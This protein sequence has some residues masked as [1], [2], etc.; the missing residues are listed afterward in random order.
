MTTSDVSV[1]QRFVQLALELDWHIPGYV[2]SYFGP[3]EWKA[4]ST[5]RGPQPIDDL[6]RQAEA[7]AA[8][9][10][11]DRSLDDQRRDYLARH[12]TAMQTSLRLLH[13]EVM[14]LAEETSLLYDVT[15]QWVDEREFEEAHRQ[16]DE[17]LQPGASLFDRLNQR[18]QSS[19]MSYAQAEPLLPVITVHLRE[20]TRARFPLP[21]DESFELFAVDNQPWR[22]YNWYLGRGRSRIDINTDL[23]LQIT[24][25]TATLAHE[26]YPGHHTELSIKD[27]RLFRAQGRLE[28]CL[29]FMNMPWCLVA[30]GIA[31]R[32]LD[33]L[34]S[35][36][37]Q[38]RWHAE[39]IFPRAGM[40]HLNAEREYQIEQAMRWLDGVWDNAAFLLHDQHRSK[41]EVS[42]YFQRYGLQRENEAA[43]AVE[44]IST[45]LQRSYVFNYR[46]GGVLLD[47]LFAAKG[48]A[49][50]WFTRLLTE[51][52]TPGQIRAWIT[53]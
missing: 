37:E 34:L 5:A 40:S 17:L 29:S 16:L 21:A 14:P 13:G 3:P 9:I 33:M 31:M 44:F 28:N 25:L 1:P 35:P 46:L 18:K 8:D 10:A 36:E 22:A 2:D 15:P 41:A 26:G 27:A 50:H 43:K 51:P 12:V 47:E 53:Q 52:V 48:N 11:Q 7:L 32:A 38:I 39:E 42:A 24:R 45:P 20:L 6:A 23:P 4:A 19:E 49:Q 30:E